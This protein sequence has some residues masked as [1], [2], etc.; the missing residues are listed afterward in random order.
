MPEW[1]AQQIYN[2]RPN[3]KAERKMRDKGFNKTDIREPR[4]SHWDRFEDY[5]N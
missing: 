3:K 1:E 5:D 4:Q 2:S